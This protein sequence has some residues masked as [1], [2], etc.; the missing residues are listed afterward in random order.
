[1]IKGILYLLLVIVFG[2]SLIMRLVNVKELY[3]KI[4]PNQKPTSIP[5]LLFI[6]SG[7][8]VIGIILTTFF[9]YFIIYIINVFFSSLSKYAYNIGIITCVILCLG[10]TILNFIKCKKRKLSTNNYKYY[11]GVILLLLCLSTF[12]IFYAYFMRG[13]VIYT[14]PTIHSDLSPHTALTESFGNGANV[15]T[16]YMHFAN[17][18]IRYHFMFYFFTGLLKYLKLPLDMALNIPSIIGIMAT[19]ILVGLL[20]NLIS[21][22]RRAFLI[23]PLLILFRSSFDIFDMLKPIISFIPRVIANNSWYTTTPYDEWG[24]WAINL[25]AN[26]RHLMF[27]IAILLVIMMLF[28]PYFA[29]FLRKVKEYKGFKKIKYWLVDKNNWVVLDYKLLLLSSMVIIT[30]PYFHGS[31]LI[32]LLLILFGM[33]IFSENRLTYLIIAILAVI[34]AY[35][36]TNIFSGGVSNVVNLKLVLGFVVENHSFIKIIKYLIMVTGI[37]FIL[38]LMYT[39]LHRKNN[40]IFLLSLIFLLPIVFAFT[41]Q[42]SIDLLANHKFIQISIILFDVF[43][44]CFMAN[45]YSNKGDIKKKICG[46]ILIFLLTATGISEW[47][48]YINMNRDLMPFDEKSEVTLWIREN[49]ATTDTFITPYW[50]MKEVYLAGRPIY[51]GWPYYAWSAG[52]DTD[53]RNQIYRYLLRG[54]DDN[55][56]KFIETCKKEKIKYFVDTLEYYDFDDIGEA[57]YHRDYITSNLKLTKEFPEMG[58]RLY[59]IY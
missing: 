45:Y 17:D 47:F 55:I 49:T 30:L 57:D 59:K 7:G 29:N 41:F 5:E 15:P 48:I 56:E 34:S 39:Y 10:L 32:T 1:M 3:L 27:G 9:C 46:Y 16:S 20:A 23:A 35:L 13:S 2:C 40:Y 22:D 54:A 58:I 19:L 25:Y 6:I 52:H 21:N 50:S 38:G 37:T 28:I 4:N 42:L 51:Y 14:G 36:Q 33:A 44:A 24:L 31:V 18:G 8:S 11:L 43:V 26:Q 12:L 53:S